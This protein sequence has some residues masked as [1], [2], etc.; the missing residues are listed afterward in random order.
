MLQV[1][2][3]VVH[4]A[5][6]IIIIFNFTDW[7]FSLKNVILVNINS[8]FNLTIVWITFGDLID[9]SLLLYD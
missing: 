3:A 6:N 2:Y 9:F 4:H 7:I 5:A 1:L 8:I